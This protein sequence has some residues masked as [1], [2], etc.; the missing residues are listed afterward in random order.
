MKICKTEY[1]DYDNIVFLTDVSSYIKVDEPIVA[2]AKMRKKEEA[3]I[4]ISL[5]YINNL[6]RCI[7]DEIWLLE[8]DYIEEKQESRSYLNDIDTL[9]VYKL[10]I[11]KEWLRLMRKC[12]Q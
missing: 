3:V 12:S 11:R 8:R 6:L 10:A 9:F 7:N 4:D 2:A 5:G 1:I